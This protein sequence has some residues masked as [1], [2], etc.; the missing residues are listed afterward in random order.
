MP[1]CFM[2]RSAPVTLPGATCAHC[3]QIAKASEFKRDELPF[4]RKKKRKGRLKRAEELLE[5][6]EA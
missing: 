6:L 5:R 3:Q 4:R 2:C 1:T